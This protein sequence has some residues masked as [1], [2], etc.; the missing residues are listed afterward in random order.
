MNL[1]RNLR[2]DNKGQVTIEFLLLI[3]FSL[4]LIFL[5]ANSLSYETDINLAMAAAREGI[6]FG[7]TENKIA[8]YDDDA[9]TKYS[10]N[11]TPLTHNNAIT[12]IKIEKLNRG[13]DDR[14]NRTSIQIR[15][16]ASSPTLTS[17]EDRVSAGDRMNYNI[18]KS[19]AVTF[20]TT[21]L[22]NSLYNP[23][24]SNQH[25]FTTANVQWV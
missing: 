24:F 10:L 14:Y 2:N 20:N 16:Y 6:S 11:K 21:K 8:I 1:N 18:R 19:I 17:R 9:Y 5:L 15:A 3:S 22:S 25:V 4:V 7:S 12:I 13:F 23:C